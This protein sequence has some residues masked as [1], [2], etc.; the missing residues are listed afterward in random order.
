MDA[1]LPT[2]SKTYEGP[3]TT[4]SIWERFSVRPGDVIVSTPP[5]SGT[6][7]TQMIVTS[8]I[9][10]R[11][12]SPKEMGAVSPWLDCALDDPEDTKAQLDGQVIRR[13]IKSHTP[14][15][16]ITYDPRCVYLAVYRHPLDVHFSMR[17]HA[18]QMRS[19]AMRPRYP[20]DIHLAFR[21]FLEDELYDGSNDALDLHSIAYHYRSFKVWE[22]LENIHLLHYADMVADL[23]KTVARIAGILGMDVSGPMI[24]QI[25]EGTTFANLKKKA[26]AA[27]EAAEEPEFYLGAK[28]F[29]N[30]TSRKWEGQLTSTELAEF[31]ARLRQLLPDEQA[32]WLLWGNRGRP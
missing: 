15:D 7:W 28:F 20:E 17:H 16:G 10:G 5:K 30:A 24:D 9:A 29:N 22:R 23:P 18:F 3:L 11:P 6:T 25:A 27:D 8:L 4:S 12:L 19:D 13:C 21:M 31:D 14:L 2:R 26:V 1:G 32:D